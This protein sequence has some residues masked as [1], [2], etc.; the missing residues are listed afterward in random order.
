M[1][2]IVFWGATLWGMRG[3]ISTLSEFLTQRN[4]V[5][6]CHRENVSLLVKQRI[7]VSEPPV[8]FFLGGGFLGV[9][10]VIHL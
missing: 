1:H 4:L 5:A 6:K 2:K 10:Y 8:Y 9:T 3:N 7:R